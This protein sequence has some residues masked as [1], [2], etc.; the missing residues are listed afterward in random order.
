MGHGKKGVVFHL[1][2]QNSRRLTQGLKPMSKP[3]A[4]AATGVHV[5]AQNRFR[6]RFNALL[7]LPFRI[8]EV[9]FF[10]IIEDVDPQAA[11]T[12]GSTSCELCTAGKYGRVPGSHT[13]SSI[14]GCIACSPGKFSNIPGAED[15]HTD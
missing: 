2:T 12:A 1:P 15:K 8:F 14:F 13:N 9:S 5:E 11:G 7:E 6:I 4:V 10:S 3:S